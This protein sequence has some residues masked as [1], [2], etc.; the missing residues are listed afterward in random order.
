MLKYA[1]HEESCSRAGSNFPKAPRREIQACLNKYC[2]EM[3][4]NM[5]ED[6]ADLRLLEADL[7]DLEFQY[8]MGEKLR[9]FGL[10]QVQRSDNHQFRVGNPLY[11]FIFPD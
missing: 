3:D 8:H 11:S 4:Q 6:E 5:K 10:R 1:E 7:D 2:N 9:E